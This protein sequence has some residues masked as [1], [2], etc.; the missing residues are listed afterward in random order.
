MLPVVH[1]YFDFVSPYACLAFHQLPRALDGLA[2]QVRYR[3]VLLGGL[4]K[5]HGTPP[6]V[7]MPQRMAWSRQHTRWLAQQ[8]DMPFDWP[9]QHP[10]APF[11]WLRMALAASPQGEPGRQVCGTLFDAIWRTGVQADDAGLQQQVWQQLTGLL[12]EVRDPASPEVKAGL[13]ANGEE[14]LSH[15]VW[16]VPTLVLMPQEEGAAAELFWGQ[17]GLPLLREALLARQPDAAA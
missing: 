4:L 2:Y 10:F 6:P 3:P 17:D 1:F 7:D 5:A 8:M 9:V 15:G 14:A 13:I 16:G 11:P 12:P